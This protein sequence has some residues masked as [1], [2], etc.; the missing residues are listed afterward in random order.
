MFQ[1]QNSVL[2]PVVESSEILSHIGL[3]A[4]GA[5]E[6]PNFSC[7]AQRSHFSGQEERTP[8]KIPLEI[9]HGEIAASEIW[10]GCDPQT[11]DAD[12]HED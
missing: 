12:I 3:Q 6:H 7:F 2:Y 1:V 5:P 11:L 9:F 4:K 8:L 10:T